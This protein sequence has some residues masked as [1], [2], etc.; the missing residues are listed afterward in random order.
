MMRFLPVFLL[1][2]LL[3]CPCRFLY[4]DEGMWLLSL[5][6]EMNYSR[7]KE[8][9]CKLT[10]EDIYNTNKS[11]LKDA[12][13]IFGGGCTGEVISDKGLILTNLHCG[14]DEIQA[15]STLQ[16]DYLQ[17]GFWAGS[18]LE[19]LPN[20]GL[21]VTFL[22]RMEDVTDRIEAKLNDKMD[23]TERQS[24]ID[25]ISKSIEKEA[26]KNTHYQAEVEHFFEGN[27]F[28]LFVYEKYKDVRLVGNPPVSIG[29]FGSLT[30]NWM[31][32]RHKADFALF[33]VYT[34]PDGKPAEYAPEN[35]PL[36]PKH[37]LPV[38][39]K[40]VNEGDF[41]MIIG[42]PGST[43][44]YM[45]SFGVMEI[46]KVK[47]PCRIKIR[48]TKLDIINQTMQKSPELRLKYAAKYKSSS[49]YWKYSIGQNEGIEDYKLLEKQ[50][51]AEKQL[52]DWIQSKNERKAQYEK[53]LPNLKSAYN[54]RSEYYKAYYYVLEALIYGPEMFYFSNRFKKLYR[55]LTNSPGSADI[56][57]KIKELKEEG[58]LYFK[59]FDLQTDKDISKALFKIFIEDIEPGFYP[60]IFK[61]IKTSY[62]N[63]IE[64][65][66]DKA[67]NKSIFSDQ[68]RYNNFLEAPNTEKLKN[69]PAYKANLSFLNQYRF[70]RDGLNSVSDII[71]QNNRLLICALQEM[72]PEK[73]FYPDANR[74]LRLTYGKV[75]GYMGKNNTTFKYYTDLE[76]V[77][78][79]E[80]SSNYEFI[81][82]PKLKQLFNQKNY[83]EYGDNGTMPVCFIT[84]TDITGG[85][86]GSP[87]IGANGE[88]LGVAFDTNWEGLT[89][90]I[91]YI[92]DKQRTICTDIRYILFVIDK[93]A[94]AGHIVN[95][96]T[97]V[98]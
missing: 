53:V 76:G 72:N 51:Q 93:F 88:L 68:I 80:D 79:K 65:F 83:G 58:D 78:R 12:V 91:K 18:L 69:D 16:N 89:G 48:T 27:Q 90:D 61:E 98:E 26:V 23:E 5:I 13:I 87:V 25:E 85:S 49:N 45:S 38:S 32:P 74:T 7:M 81:V 41:T 86:S 44:R 67:Y 21:T 8:M 1:L 92:A 34:S 30:D 73:K 40:G 54:S 57:A 96:M 94:D 77:I 56:E 35:I 37:H 50:I 4:A 95:E 14:Y 10:P 31:W 36:K 24:V 28:F 39:L 71:D 60:D 17:N 59:N 97:I 29:D 82:S 3:L 55:L 62:E 64:L 9:G 46:Y 11:S 19:E 42:R 6:K 70:L 33:R 47:N 22:V 84:N 52:T 66:I 75:E 15:H 2:F 63:K 20:P 43:N